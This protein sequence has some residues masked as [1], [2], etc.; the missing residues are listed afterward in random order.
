MTVPAQ[1]TSAAQHPLAPYG[2]DEGW[3]LALA[4]HHREHPG[5]L[6]PARVTRAHRGAL[7]VRTPLGPQRVAAARGA[8]PEPTTGDWVVLGLAGGEPRLLA[9]LPRRTAVTRADVS[10]RSDEQVLAAN[11]DTVAVVVAPAR[12][13]PL[14]RVER[15]LALAWASG[16]QPVVVLTKTD[17]LSGPELAEAL[18]EVE[19]AAP[20]AGVHAVSAERGAG[21]EDLRAALRGTVALVGPSGAGKSTL[22]NALLGE[23]RL[24]TAAVRSG[25]GKGRHTTVHRELLAVPGGLVLVD[26]PGL[27]SVGLGAEGPAPSV[28][29]AF[30]DVEDLAVDCRFSDCTHACEPGCAVLAA[31][32]AGV[33]GRRR[34]E[35]YRKLE[36]EREFFAARTDARLR[37]ERAGR[38]KAIARQQRAVRPRP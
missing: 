8:L 21:V 36:R 9:V 28:E 18:A 25:D 27:R 23:D 30:A 1:E 12:R 38:W 3:E 4:R 19:A 11:V 15:F 24:A 6:V 33:I 2:W 35:S 7:D 20:G 29:R 26:T 5:P 13:A 10:G 16:A 37:A 34:L 31:I 22:A 17:L 14:G 32:D